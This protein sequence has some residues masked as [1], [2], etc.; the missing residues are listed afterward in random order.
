MAREKGK[1]F[2]WQKWALIAGAIVLILIVVFAAVFIFFLPSF[3]AVDEKGEPIPPE[4]PEIVGRL[5]VVFGV[6]IIG[7]IFIA[8]ILFFIYEVFFKKKELHIVKEHHKIVREAALLNPVETMNDLVLTGSNRVQHYRLGRIV[9]HTQVPVKFERHIV[10]GQDGKENSGLSESKQAFI[11]R[12]K[13][14]KEAGKDR[15]DFFAFVN[16]RGIYK[17]PF[18]S[19]LEPPKIFACYPSERSGD[20]LGDVEIHDVG[21]WKVSGVNIFIPGERSKEPMHTVKEFETQLM[22]IA[23]MGILDYVGLVAQRG[24]E[25]DTSM[26]KWLQN[27]ASVV[28]IKESAD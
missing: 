6:I 15:Y 26:Q 9:G 4:M 11:K 1:G 5:A 10:I 14:A 7:L 25:G 27:K 23:Y 28:N 17:L 12:V 16:N 21:T 13:E 20:L 2:N 22:P 19:L 3:V 8:G 24:I 18:F